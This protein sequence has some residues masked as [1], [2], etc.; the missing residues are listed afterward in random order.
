MRLLLDH[1]VPH[2]LRDAFPGHDVVTA[3]Y[4]GWAGLTN[5]QLLQAA[6][7]EFD[8]LITLDKDIQHQQPTHRYDIAI[9]VLDVHPPDEHHLRTVAT[10]L[11]PRLN[12]L[13]A[14]TVT[15]FTLT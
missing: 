10:R 9:A 8:V 11:V 12:D 3:R 6:Q 14:G 7:Q 15:W 1:M 2:Y 5:G 13:R 4:R